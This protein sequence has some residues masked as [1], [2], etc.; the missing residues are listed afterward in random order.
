M[1]AIEGLTSQYG[2]VVAVRSVDLHVDAGEIVALVGSIGAGKSTLMMTVMGLHHPSAGRIGFESEDITGLPTD[3]IVRRGV[4]LIPERRRIFA[5]LTVR[6][7]L[8]LGTAARRDGSSAEA[9]IAELLELFP[10]LEKRVDGAAGYLSG[11][12]AQQLAIARALVGTPRLLLLDEPS[13]GLAPKIAQSVFDLLSRLR[14][15]GLTLLLVEQNAFQ[16]LAIADRGYVMRSGTIEAG[17]S[18]AE[19]LRDRKLIES[20]LGVRSREAVGG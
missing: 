17:G 15:Q 14:D 11:G 16:A 9:D 19:L 5:E 12:E 13:L 18:S 3:K 2:P 8:L 20:Y 7:N 6:E 1:L 4:S 10:A